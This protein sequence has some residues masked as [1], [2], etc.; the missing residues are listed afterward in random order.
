[1]H[2]NLTIM[3]NTFYLLYIKNIIKKQ[4]VEIILKIKKTLGSYL[5]LYDRLTKKTAYL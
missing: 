1:M 4:K 3:I 5:H 2:I